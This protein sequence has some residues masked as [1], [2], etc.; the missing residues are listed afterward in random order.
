MGP[1]PTSCFMKYRSLWPL[2][3]L[4]I[5][6]CL[7]FHWQPTPCSSSTANFMTNISARIILQKFDS[8]H[9]FLV[10]CLA[11]R[12]LCL[13]GTIFKNMKSVACIFLS[14]A[15]VIRLHCSWLQL[16]ESQTQDNLAFVQIAVTSWNHGP[17]SWFSDAVKN[18]QFSYARFAGVLV[19]IVCKLFWLPRR[20]WSF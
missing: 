17:K 7:I 13:F 16:P 6:M 10:S 5:C 11:S 14:L 1:Q 15:S 19:Q 8:F 18:A 3:Y 12:L 9:V 20:Y 2:G 4:H